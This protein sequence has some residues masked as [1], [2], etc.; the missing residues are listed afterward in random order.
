MGGYIARPQSRL[1]ILVKCM[2]LTD[3]D[4]SYDA[5][6][7]VGVGV[8]HLQK[9][10]ARL[11]RSTRVPCPSLTTTVVSTDSPPPTCHAHPTSLPSNQYYSNLGPV[12]HPDRTVVASSEILPTLQLRP[13]QP[14]PGASLVSSRRH[15]PIPTINALRLRLRFTLCWREVSGGR[16]YVVL[17][18]CLGSL[19]RPGHVLYR[20]W[21]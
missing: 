16:C 7:G 1:V 18:A 4:I 3:I 8:G 11:K 14:G 5:S 12:H 17:V 20:T 19:D 15:S 9:S 13:K 6:I 21:L 2:T 10:P